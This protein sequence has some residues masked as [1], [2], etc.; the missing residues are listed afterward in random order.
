MKKR[1][2]LLSNKYTAA[3][4]TTY[5]KGQIVESE[6]DLMASFANK[7]IDLESLSAD[8]PA[9]IVEKVVYCW[10]DGSMHDTPYAPPSAEVDPPKVEA[11]QP[12]AKKEAPSPTTKKK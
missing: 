11:P 9:K 5:F 1:Y 8:V 3:D 6:L 2:K 10:P 4:G 7:F 12:E